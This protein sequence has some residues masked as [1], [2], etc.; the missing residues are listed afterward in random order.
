MDYF[1]SFATYELLFRSILHLHHAK[2]EIGFLSLVSKTR[3]VGQNT[4]HWATFLTIRFKAKDFK[5]IKSLD[6]SKPFG[7]ICVRIFLGC[8]VL[9]VYTLAD[10]PYIYTLQSSVCIAF[11]PLAL[12]VKSF[13][14]YGPLSW[15]MKTSATSKLMCS[16]ECVSRHTQTSITTPET[17]C[18]LCCPYIKN[19]QF[20][21][22]FLWKLIFVCL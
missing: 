20:I 11:S 22:S 6:Y 19:I 14:M 12:F 13:T 4:P 9:N 16:Q 2:L 8:T 10:T 3:L 21:S 18:A 1:N 7:F 15:E 17:Y 5:R